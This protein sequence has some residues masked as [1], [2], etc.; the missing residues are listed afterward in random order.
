[1]KEQFILVLFLITESFCLPAAID[2][3]IAIKQPCPLV[4]CIGPCPNG[5]IKNKFGCQT[6]ECN[7]CKF[8]QPWNKY[9]CGQG[10]N[11]CSANNGLCKI[12]TADFSYCCPYEKP[13][14]CPPGPD[15]A[16]VLCLPATCKTDNDC[17]KGQK[18]CGPCM[19]CV[20]AIN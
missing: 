17:S 18:C 11:T 20:D 8:D 19:Q 6:C 1:M 12:S 2:G 4:K 3:T 16:V 10:L 13:G 15:P 9:T 5:F 14:C 7:P